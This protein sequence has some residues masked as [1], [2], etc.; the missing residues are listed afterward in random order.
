MYP[1]LVYL[2]FDTLAMWL[3]SLI[4]TARSQFYCGQNRRRSFLNGLP[5]MQRGK[6]SSSRQSK[7]VGQ[8]SIVSVRVNGSNPI[9]DGTGAKK[10]YFTET[11]ISSILL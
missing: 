5:R 11:N 3:S 8:S 10:R 2:F 9:K 1:S 4:T 7:E 6:L